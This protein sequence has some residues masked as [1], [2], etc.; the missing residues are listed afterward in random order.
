MTTKIL[1][2]SK[3]HLGLAYSLAYKRAIKE[4][5]FFEKNK[6]LSSNHF[7]IC[8]QHALK[9]WGLHQCVVNLVQLIY[10]HLLDKTIKSKNF[11]AATM[12]YY[13]GFTFSLL[14][15]ILFIFFACLF[16][17]NKKMLL[18]YNWKFDFTGVASNIEL[19]KLNYVEG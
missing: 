6:L 15:L 12:Y 19:G 8:R 13:Q 14:Y 11:S 18:H 7:Y 1:S 3:I 4:E 9:L 10:T 16:F 17:S 2:V 5:I